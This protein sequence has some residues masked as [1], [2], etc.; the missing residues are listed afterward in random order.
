MEISQEIIAN[1]D[2]DT[3]ADLVDDISRLLNIR[4]KNKSMI[5][6]WLIFISTSNFKVTPGEIYLAFKMAISREIFDSKGNEI[7]IFPELSNNTTGKV[8]AA[9][10]KFK[11]ESL[12]YQ[13][14][15]ENLK[16]LKSPVN[17]ISETEKQ[18]IKLEFLKVVFE[19]IKEKG[20]SDNAWQLFDQLEKSGKIKIS[21]EEKKDLY[22]KQLRIYE[23]ESKAIIRNKYAL[24]STIHINAL[25]DKINK[26]KSIESVANKCRSII[27]S[28]YLSQFKDFNSFLNEVS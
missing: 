26:S 3:K 21:V 15:K 18:K 1:V 20:F 14:A 16:L 19:E 13:N 27:A 28:K 12:A 2:Y 9:Y 6:D 24:E 23:I 22:K 8:I 10:L 7:D 5:K 11:K 25:M 17:E 4:D